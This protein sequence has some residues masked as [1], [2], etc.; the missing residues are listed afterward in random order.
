MYSCTLLM[1]KT[2][3][4]PR[5]RRLLYSCLLSQM[6]RSSNKNPI[7][8]ILTCQV[9]VQREEVAAF[10]QIHNDHAAVAAGLENG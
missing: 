2:L 1:R 6:M 10:P 9:G 7:S 5:G 3:G 8:C 4:W